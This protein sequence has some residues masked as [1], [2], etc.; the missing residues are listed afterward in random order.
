MYVRPLAWSSSAPG[1]FAAPVRV[2]ARFSAKLTGGASDRCGSGADGMFTVDAN[3]HPQLEV[4]S[5]G[6][7]KL[8]QR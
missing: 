7:I 5:H 6:K 8:V 2:P 3:P 1:R 4:Y